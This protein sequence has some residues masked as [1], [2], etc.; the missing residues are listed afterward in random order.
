MPPNDAAFRSLVP[1]RGSL[2]RPPKVQQPPPQAA[3][4]RDTLPAQRCGLRV[5]KA[6]GRSR[7]RSAPRSDWPPLDVW[8]RPTMAVLEALLHDALGILST[9]VF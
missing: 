3:L 9:L 2:I 5:T 8:I 7:S 4:R 6:R 1:A